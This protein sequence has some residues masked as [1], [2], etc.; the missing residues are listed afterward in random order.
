MCVCVWKR[1]RGRGSGRGGGRGL[2]RGQMR[3]KGQGDGIER[4]G[5]R[6]EGMGGR[7][8]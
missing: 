2:G 7:G 6:A 3:G 8:R 4:R 1:R 5:Q